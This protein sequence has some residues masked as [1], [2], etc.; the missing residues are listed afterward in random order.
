[1]FGAHT[2]FGPTESLPLNWTLGHREI[3]ANA[4]ALDGALI[5]S[6]IQNQNWQEP[7]ELCR[8]LQERGMIRIAVGPREGHKAFTLQTLPARDDSTRTS[9]H[10]AKAAGFSLHAGVAVEPEKRR[11]LERLARYITA[12]PF[13]NNASR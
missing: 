9:D 11:K 12:P 2:R 4:V 5:V 1:M 3:I 13:L 6:H 10:L 8:R 7:Y